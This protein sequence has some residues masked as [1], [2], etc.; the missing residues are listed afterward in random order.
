MRRP[1]LLSP[2]GDWECLRAAIENGADA[3]YFGIDGGFNARMRAANFALSELSAVMGLLHRRGLKGYVALNTLVFSGE[4]PGI[5]RLVRHVCDAGADAILAQDVGF[6]KLV[7][8][9][10]PDLPVHASTQMTLTSAECL[11]VARE[12]GIARAVAARELSIAEI[13]SIIQEC[14]L[15][16]EVFVHGAL[17]VA[18]SGQCLTSESLG[19]RSANRGICAQACRLPYQLVCDGQEVDLGAVRYLLSPQDLAAYALVPDLIAAGVAALKIEGR[20]K[21]PDYVANIT[22]H[23][24]LAIDAAVSG[25]PVEFSPRQIE[26]MELSFSRGFSPGWLAGNDHKRLVPGLSCSK[27][28]V[29]LGHVVSVRGSRIAVALERQVSAGDGVAFEAVGGEELEQGGRIFAIYRRG[30]RMTE[31]IDHGVVELVFARDSVDARRVQAGK[32]VWKTDDPRLTARLRATYTN[33]V[34]QRRVPLDI[35]AEAVAGQP[36]RVIAQADNGATCQVESKTPLAVAQRHPLTEALL[37]QQ[38]GR[39]GKTVY[40]LRR[41]TANISGDTMLPLSV[42]GSMRHEMVRRLD[43]WFVTRPRRPLAGDDVLSKLRTRIMTA[44]QAETQ[45]RSDDSALGDAGI[46]LHVLCRSREQLEVAADCGV[47]SVIADFCD[48]RQYRTA[49]QIARGRRVPLWLATPRIQKPG[50]TGIF[51]VL[52]RHQPSGFVARNLS[53]LRFYQERNQAAVAD[54]SLNAANELTVAYLRQQGAQRVTAAYDLN[55]D[56]L[57]ELVRAV[58]AR[59]LEVV[60]HQHMPLFHMEHCVFCAVLSPGTNRTNCGRPCDRHR[61]QLR[62]RVG[63]KHFLTADV[64]CRNTLFNATAQSGAEVAAQLLTLGVRHYRVELVDEDAE[65]SRRIITL[66]AELLAGR[67]AGRAVW[68]E[69][70]AANRVGV[71]RGTLE[72][73]RDPLAIL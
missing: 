8:E 63:V 3:V 18:Y 69:L 22:R 58:P 59:W 28:G 23:Y 61:V 41:V 60:L 10:C 72:E 44:A 57:L 6:V 26:E 24:R 30:Q 27:R 38:L 21:K 55:R 70:R 29:R 20:L 25:R 66:Y 64:G 49:V 11:A 12:L 47:A 14:D 42:L 40:E 43:D 33:S 51:R 56:Q 7:R 9:V 54:F 36:L 4:L 45:Q 46:Q 71:T 53:G 48:I 73:R 19:G 39:L 52:L 62:D 37:K 31:A 15:P 35:V 50:E 13:R 16:L 1:E 32:T 2:A 17:C 65:E 68:R 5:E 34:P 67:S